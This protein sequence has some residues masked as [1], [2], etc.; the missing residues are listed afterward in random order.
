MFLLSYSIFFIFCVYFSY[1]DIRY[2]ELSRLQLWTAIVIVTGIRVAANF[3]GTLLGG[4][5]GLLLFGLAYYVSKKRM[6]LADVWFSAFAGA[7]L[8]IVKW[9]YAVGIACIAALLFFMCSKNRTVP[10]IPFLACGSCLTEGVCLL[11]SYWKIL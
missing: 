1:Q 9:Y 3:I 7:F 2:G 4:G 11:F 8:G 10:F 5:T 6:G